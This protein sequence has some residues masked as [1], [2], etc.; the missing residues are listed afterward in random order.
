MHLKSFNI[1]KTLNTK[2]RK[3]NTECILAKEKDNTYQ[4]KKGRNLNQLLISIT[5]PPNPS[6]NPYMHVLQIMCPVL[7]KFDNDGN[8]SAY[9]YGEILIIRLK[10]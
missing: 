7:T 2:H 3:L 8:I 4:D 6:P 5:H 10:L 1:D 9:A